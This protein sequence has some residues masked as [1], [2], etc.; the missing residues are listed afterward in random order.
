M[1]YAFSEHYWVFPL[2]VR[3]GMV[4][5]AMKEVGRREYLLS[6]QGLADI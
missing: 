5:T 6:N 2:K 1:P 4:L 3:E